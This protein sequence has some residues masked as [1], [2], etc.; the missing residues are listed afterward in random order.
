MTIGMSAMFAVQIAEI[1]FVARLGTTS[2]AAISFTFPLVF[3]LNSIAFGIGIGCSSLMS[4]HIGGG[5][6]TDARRIAS[7]G[8]LLVL[9][10]MSVGALVGLVTIDPLFTLMGASAE[11][12]VLIHSYLE[13]YYPGSV[14]L[15][16]GMVMSSQL[17]AAGNARVPALVM[18]AGSL[19]NL[20]LAPLL[21]FG[22][23][24][25]PRLE[26][27]G[28]AAAAVIA[29]GVMMVALL[30]YVTRIERLVRWQ[31]ES[32]GQSWREILSIGIPAMATQ[33]IGPVSTAVITAM[34]ADYGETIVAGF[35]VASRIEGV[36]VMLLFALSASIGPFVGQNWGAQRADRVQRGLSL[37]YRFCLAWGLLTFVAL[38]FAAAPLAAMFNDDPSVVDT[39][40]LY[41][42][43]VPISYGPWGV[44]MMASASFNSLGRPIPS[45][46]MSFVRMFVLYIPLA[47]A[48]EVVLGYSGIFVAAAAANCI[49]ALTGFVWLRHHLAV[50]A[51]V[52]RG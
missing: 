35:G 30:I 9:V 13:I 16:L 1:W 27:A 38:W 47:M 29:R 34:L 22:M 28:A 17:R 33:L 6:W 24:G 19:L 43:I 10:L 8:L 21:I 39:A 12:L 4:R 42:M 15:T 40:A 11:T 50:N 36:F 18:T 49:M 31:L 45:T 44:L 5:K 3:S 46:I 37:A 41:L 51:R 26:L 14:L 25:L 20:A 23:G 2:L 48:C 52:P 32:L 7:H